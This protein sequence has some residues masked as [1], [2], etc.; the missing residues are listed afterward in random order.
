MARRPILSLCWT[1][2]RRNTSILRP[3]AT[4]SHLHKL[5]IKLTEDSYQIALRG[6]D[7]ADVL[8]SHRNFIKAGADE[9]NEA[10]AEKTVHVFPVELFIRGFAAHGTT[11][12]MRCGVQRL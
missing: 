2:N 3:L 10:L 11:G 4:R 9:G 12:A 8:V 1:A 5:R 7:F 6:H